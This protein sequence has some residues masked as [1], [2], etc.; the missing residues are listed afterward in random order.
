MREAMGGSMLYYIIIPILFLFITF[1]A[2]IMIYAS[3]YRASNYIISQIETCDGSLADGACAH[4][5]IEK[6]V[7]YV[8]SNYHYTRNIDYCYITNKKG[9]M[10][11]VTLYVAFDI[12][13]LGD[14]LLAFPVGTETKT[15]Y[16][17]FDVSNFGTNIGVCK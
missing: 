10:F 2:F 6:M 8:R 17:V 7:A 5:S 16:N 1:M 15:L 3:T 14:D 13:F 11:K 4:N 9:T 12:P